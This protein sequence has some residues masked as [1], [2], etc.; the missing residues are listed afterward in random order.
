MEHVQPRTV[1][2]S[3]GSAHMGT[4]AGINIP[5]SVR[6]KASEANQGEGGGTDFPG[7]PPYSKRDVRPQAR[8]EVAEYRTPRRKIS[9]SFSPVRSDAVVFCDS[10]FSSN[11][12]FPFLLRET[13]LSEI[14]YCVYRGAVDL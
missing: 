2:K 12:S 10:Q 11:R 7:N 6:G 8:A 5:K 14:V 4:G 13:T 9:L 1:D 3:S